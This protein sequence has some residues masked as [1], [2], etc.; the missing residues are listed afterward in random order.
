MWDH[1]TQYVKQLLFP[2]TLWARLPKVILEQV[3]SPPLV[4]PTH[5]PKLQF[6][7][8]MHFCIA[9]LQTPHWL[10]WAPNICHQNY[11]VLWTDP[12]IQ[13]PDSSLDPSDLPSQPAYIS[14]QP[15]CHNA[16][17]R[18]THRPTDGW[19]ECSLTIGSF[20]SYRER[21]SL[22]ILSD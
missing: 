17:D 15:F 14:N 6:W 11:L 3:V 5:H 21:H 13:L 9:I 19:R 20:R 12:Q 8:F 2:S 7:P 18:Q 1:H 22:I 10:Q 16:L 4:D